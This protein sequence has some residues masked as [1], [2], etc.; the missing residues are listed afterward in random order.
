MEPNNYPLMVVI[1]DEQDILTAIKRCFMRIDVD[2][3][4]FTSPRLALEFLQINKPDIVIS[5]HGMPDIT[6][7]E[8]LKQVKILWPE[9]KRVML[10][11]YQEFDLV[12]VGFNDGILDKFISKPWKNAEL[13]FLVEELKNKAGGILSP[14][15]I[16]EEFIGSHVS[17]TKLFK[18]I[19]KA[20]GTNVPIFIHGETGTGKELIAK[21]CHELGPRNK[22]KFVAVNCAN[23]SETLIESQ[24]FGHKK[25]AFTGAVNNQE[26]VFEYADGGTVFLDEITTLPLNLQSKLLRVIQE[27]TFSPIGS[28]DNKTFDVQIISASSTL[29]ADS[30]SKGEFREDL[31]YRLCVIPLSIPPLRERGEDIKNLALYFLKKFARQYEKQFET[32]DDA[33]L[34]FIQNHKWPGNVRQ[35][36]NIVHGVCV[37]NEGKVVDLEMLSSLLKDVNTSSVLVSN[38]LSKSTLY[39]TADIEPLHQIERKAIEQ[40]LNQCEGSV[41]KAAA[42]LE[43]NPSTLYRKIKQWSEI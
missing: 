30:V 12:M 10:S 23:F 1:D 17:I 15:K 34:K 31:Y 43:V 8:L 32:Y 14:A 4:T 37:L 22:K 5:D 38:S 25:G 16:S 33:C 39:N 13:R 26:G 36:E 27:R 6:G 20:A 41:N 19:E 40:A 7:L 35:L 21:A 2:I 18:D 11:A 3:E 9:C 24:L 42:I 29:L 28:L